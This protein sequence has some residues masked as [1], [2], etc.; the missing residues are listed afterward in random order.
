MSGVRLPP[1]DGKQTVVL[2]M[3]AHER[4]VGFV[5]LPD[6]KNKEMAF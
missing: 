4:V 5:L 1:G 3:P 2:V 6:H